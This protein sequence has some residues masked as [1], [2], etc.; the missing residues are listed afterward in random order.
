[1]MLAIAYI[2]FWKITGTLFSSTSRITPPAEPVIVPMMIATQK[3]WPQSSVFCKPATVNSA[4]PSVSKKNQVLSSRFNDRAKTMTNI[5]A[6][7]VQMRYIDDVIQ[8]GV[9]PSI[10]S[11]SV[12][13][14]I[15]TATPQT[16]PPNQSKRLAAAWRMP[17]MANAKVPRNSMTLS[18]GW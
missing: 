11:R 8:N 2:S 6:M 9:T 5:C 17:E 16:K 4:R 12:P 15:A 1:M 13:P 14:P 10:M 3:A 18:K 7:N